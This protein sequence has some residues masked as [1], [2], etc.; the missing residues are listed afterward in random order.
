MRQAL[1][2]GMHEAAET[3]RHDEE[4]INKAYALD[5]NDCMCSRHDGEKTNKAYAS[6]DNYGNVRQA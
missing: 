6:N 2:Q 1:L 3:R 5:N 4:N